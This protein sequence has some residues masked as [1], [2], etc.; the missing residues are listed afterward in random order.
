MTSMPLLRIDPVQSPGDIRRI[1]SLA[2]EIWMEHYPPLIGLD[3]VRYMLELFQSVPALERQI[4]AGMHYYM[5]RQDDLPVGY[6]ATQ[7][8]PDSLFLSKLYVHKTLRGQGI[9]RQALRFVCATEK[10][11]RITLTVNRH[12]TLALTAYQRLGFQ[13]LREEKTDIGRGFVMDDFVLEWLPP[14]PLP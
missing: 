14:V 10:P 11:E 7:P 6:L 4:N 8:E 3:Q 9:A 12:N 1:A 13:V 2:H 5:L